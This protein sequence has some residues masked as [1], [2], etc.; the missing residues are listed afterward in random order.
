MTQLVDQ[1]TLQSPA[2]DDLVTAVQKVLRE[3][4]EPLT[5]SKIRAQLPPALRNITPEEL[6]EV[7]QRQV[8]ANV[9][10]Q[11][12]KYRSQ[13]DRFWDRPM[14]VHVAALIQETL[15]EGALNWS[16]LRRKLPQYAQEPAADV[17]QSELTAGRLYRYPRAG[18]GGERYGVRPPDPKDY[19][20]SE[21][22][23]V[24]ARLEQLGF[25]QPQLRASAL[26]LLHEEEW[27][28]TPAPAQSEENPTEPPNE[29]QA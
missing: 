13:Q 7:L 14:P 6:T 15:T 26:E 19:L 4:P 29:P 5:V 18:R 21:L 17:L 1:A 3:S 25:T 11:Y 20:R 8:T 2:T 22:Q 23:T 27:A 28:S 16:E 10:I 9:L 24:F 12:P